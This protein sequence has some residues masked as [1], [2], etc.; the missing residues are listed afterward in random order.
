MDNIPEGYDENGVRSGDG[1]WYE[2]EDLC[3]KCGS[4]N[5][6]RNSSDFLICE[7]CGYEEVPE[8]EM[9]VCDRCGADTPEVILINGLCPVCAEEMGVI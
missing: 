3:P 6:F 4:D 1:S 8:D 7:N 2:F 9:G 5:V